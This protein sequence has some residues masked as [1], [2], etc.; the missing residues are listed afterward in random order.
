MVT[1]I[2]VVAGFNI[3]GKSG[4]ILVTTMFFLFYDAFAV[5]YLNI[6]WLYALEINNLQMR[7]QGS[8]LA[9]ASNGLFNGVVVTINPSRSGRLAGDTRLFVRDASIIAVSKIIDCHLPNSQG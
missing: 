4:G 8:A 9:C 3:G 5:S 2:L 6:P 7:A 1:L